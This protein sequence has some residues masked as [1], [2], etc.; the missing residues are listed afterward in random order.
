[1]SQRIK[2]IAILA[3]V[4]AGK[5]TTTEQLLFLNGKTRKA[6]S[7]DDGTAHTDFT[8]IERQRGISIF[9][10]SSEFECDG[11]K[12]NII[13][14]PGHT[15]FAGEAERSLVTA[16]G[17]VLVVSAVEGV[18]AYTESL[19]SAVH[20]A[21][22]PCI[23]FVNKIDRAGAS[24]ERIADDIQEIFGVK[25]FAVNRPKNGCEARGTENCKVEDNPGFYD[26][27]TELLADFDDEIAECFLDEKTPPEQTLMHALEKCM[28]EGKVV[29]MVCGSAIA[30]V[31]INE[32]AKAISRFLPLAD[33]N[34]DTPLSAVIYK[35]DHDKTMGKLAHVRLFGGSLSSRDE[36]AFDFP[37]EIILSDEQ[38]RCGKISQ[39]RK[40]D[41]GRFFDT[42]K[43]SAGDIAVLCGLSEARV[44]DIIG[45]NSAK[46]QLPD[47]KL[48]N[49]FL[50][51]KAT[52]NDPSQLT[53]LAAALREL[54]DE[55]PYLNSEWEKTESE[56][57]VSITGKIQLEILTLLLRERYGLEADFSAPTVIYKETPI[58]IG[59]GFEAYTM[60]KPCW[61][62]V[63]L[64][65]EPMP[66]GSG[67]SFDMG[68]VPHNQ[69]FYKYQE[70]IR[71]STF[72][73]TKQGI[74]G[75]E[76]TD[77]KATLI[78]GEHHTIHTHPLDFFLA[79]PI[80]FL[81][82]LTACGSKLLEP[83]LRVRIS[84]PEEC[85]GKIVGDVTLM[86][87]SFDT[88]VIKNGKVHLD[89]LIPAAECTDYPVKLA[90]LT[91]GKGSFRPKFHGYV[92]CPPGVGASTPFRGVCPLDRPKWILYKRGAIQ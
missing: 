54:S 17:A 49:P 30:G 86:R 28:K 3:H 22:I 14:T 57:L 83:V 65:M 90:S 69:L 84:A 44:G 89:C 42:G 23:V 10:A 85:M 70:H 56:I 58:G 47:G 39:I 13:D 41:G 9:S 8:P 35:I 62:V 92:D 1:M 24:F 50:R 20:E 15:D 71:R 46:T 66:R 82:A 2:N 78:G 64:L 79:T 7:V 37:G 53:S 43:V 26:E 67:V 4:D 33:T 16:D 29:P 80:A 59:E 40:A 55:E 12:V 73:S 45:E 75:W 60:P 81:R 61:A 51:V 76:V 68:N 34:E 25:T 63:H 74:H 18:E 31:G 52:P 6:G 38:K 87:G 48:A 32:L 72:E 21:K 36:V 91:S 19:W 5:T 88:P 77:F 27:L 11:V